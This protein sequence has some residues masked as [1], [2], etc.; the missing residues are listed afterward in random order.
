MH[1]LTSPMEDTCQRAPGRSHALDGQAAFAQYCYDDMLLTTMF[2]APQLLSLSDGLLVL[3]LAHLSVC[4]VLSN[5]TRQR[6]DP[7][8]AL[9]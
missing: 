4:C 9:Y 5:G 7:W 2:A 6:A 8:G 1:V 3:S